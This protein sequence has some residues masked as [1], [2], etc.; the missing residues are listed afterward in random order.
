MKLPIYAADLVGKDEGAF[1]IAL[2]QTGVYRGQV[3][4]HRDEPVIHLVADR[5]DDLSAQLGPLNDGGTGRLEPECRPL[6]TRTAY[7]ARS[8]RPTS[9]VRDWGPAPLPGPFFTKA[10]LQQPLRVSS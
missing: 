9:W 6:F 7:P 10:Y 2:S 1:G 4:V 3:Q 5:V 8:G